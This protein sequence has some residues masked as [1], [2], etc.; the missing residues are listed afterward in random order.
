[1]KFRD[2][3]N[4]YLGCDCVLPDGSTYTLQPSHLPSNWKT[5][6]TNHKPLLLSL[7]DLTNEHR[8]ELQ[9][10]TVFG[11]WPEISKQ[12]HYLTSKG[13]DVFG[14]IESG[15]AIRKTK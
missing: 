10:L 14:L 5:V 2:V 6:D 11:D 15:Q 12:F 4:F 13:Y 7:E 8:T 1:M 9:H 3:I